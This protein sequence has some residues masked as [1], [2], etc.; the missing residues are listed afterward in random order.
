M[1]GLVCTNA[2]TTEKKCQ[3][4]KDILLFKCGREL[5]LAEKDHR[6]EDFGQAHEKKNRVSVS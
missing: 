6:K 3:W 1:Q 2:E 5:E 4:L